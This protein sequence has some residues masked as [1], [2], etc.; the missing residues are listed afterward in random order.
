MTSDFKN[1]S[2]TSHSLLL[3]TLHARTISFQQHVFYAA[4]ES[5][6]IRIQALNV[7]QNRPIFV[8]GG[9]RRDLAQQGAKKR[10]IGLSTKL[11]MEP[12]TGGCRVAC[13]IATFCN[14]RR[15]FNIGQNDRA[16]LGVCLILIENHRQY[17]MMEKNVRH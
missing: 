17:D 11:D 8:T 15:Q 1:S 6:P 4:G 7:A 3:F 2:I 16:A 5:F 10:I 9:Q 13:F 14:G 12:L